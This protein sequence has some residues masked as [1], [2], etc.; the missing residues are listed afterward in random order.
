MPFRIYVN[1]DSK[2]IANIPRPW[3]ELLQASVNRADFFL[4][5]NTFS[6]GKFIRQSLN[7]TFPL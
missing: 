2:P 4:R 3:N 1:N 7:D 6:G 5:E